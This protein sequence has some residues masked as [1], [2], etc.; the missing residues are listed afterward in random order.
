MA[1]LSSA[2]SPACRGVAIGIAACCAGVV[3][4]GF[5]GAEPVSPADALA[6]F[7]IAEGFRVELFAAEPHVVDPVEMA[8]DESGGVYVAEL[9]DNP[10]DP[11]P[12][13]A[14]LSRIKYLEDRDGDGVIDSHTVFADRLLA[15]EGIAPWKGGLIATAA[16]DILYLKDLDGDRRADLREVLYTGFALAHVEGRLSNPRLGLDNWFYVV[17]HSYPGKIT[18][19]Q[20]PDDPPVNVRNREFRFHPLRGLAEP[21]TGNA[22]FGQSYN[23]WGHWFISHNT[24][25]LRHTVIP[26]GYLRRNPL[27]TV[28]STAQDISDHGRPTAPVFPISKPQQWRIDRTEVRQARFDETQ[29]GRVERL[30]GFFTASS[31]ATVYLGD[32][33]PEGFAGR[34]FVAEGTGNLVH[35]DIVAPSGPTYTA[36]RWPS[37]SDFL[38]S[39]DSWFRP[40]NLSNAPDGNLY[41]LDYYRQYLEHPMFIPEAV[42]RRLNMDFRAGDTLGRIYRIVPD[43]PRSIRPPAVD[44]ESATGEDLVALLEHPNGWHRRT[45]HRLLVERQETA[46]VSRLRAVAREGRL[47]NARLHALWVLEGLD[48]LDADLVA[49]AL[50]DEHPAIRENAIRLA[51]AQLTRFQQQILAATR[52]EDPRVAL[53]AALTAGSFPGSTRV[54]EALADVL[55][56]FPE[57][58]WFRVAV[59]SAPSELAVSV[60]ER[61]IRR[62]D[63]FES[64]TDEKGDLLRDFA[65]TVAARHR[66]AELERLLDWLVNAG[67]MSPSQWK[68]AML[69]GMEEGLAVRRGERVRSEG[70]ARLLELLLGDAS[71]AVR[72]AATG[73][74]RYFDLGPYLRRAIIDAGDDRLPVDQR[75]LAIRVLQ[76]GSYG[77][78]AGALGD[79]LSKEGDPRLRTAAAMSLA[80]FDDPEVARTLVDGWPGYAPATRDVIA[81]LLIRR[82]D[83]AL[84]FADEL[85]AG[86]VNPLDIPAVTRIRFAN[87]PDDE[88]RARVQGRLQLGAGDRDRVVVEHLGVIGLT[89]EPARGKV[90]FDREC[91]SCHLRRN[92]RGRIGPD[93]SGVNNLSKETLLTSILDPSHSIEDRYRNHLLETT[94]GRFYDGI[95]I[96]ETEET[97]TLRGEIEDVTV[98]KTDV[99]EMRESGVSLMPEG[100]EDALSDQELADVIAFLRAGL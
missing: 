15:V 95:L 79:A 21:S 44:I 30:Q 84:A 19:P 25:H 75:I 82:R 93:L 97:V 13:D 4:C 10:D 65:R 87:H 34:V 66:P 7:R 60:L 81:E 55:Y 47:P 99:A 94:D 72:E 86:R 88:V 31:G 80:S 62:S 74:A 22:Q 52:D 11:P 20:R 63:I 32:Q 14:P 76:G 35:C 6:T 85:A 78:V 51:E 3:S 83:L 96:A 27:L 58:P 64:V 56:R 69:R 36:T 98:L 50:S 89:G 45:A 49:G 2:A 46:E 5:R 67:E 38:A 68:T 43:R 42:K 77:D 54:I 90:A 61:L 37:D 1:A 9:L 40:V 16:P 39:A 92:S 41:V 48:S 53:Q 26:P 33:F 59:L 23:E 24:V 17:N 91:A 71:E 12:G 70:A 28:E 57:D 18:S 8:F 29:P 73:I 100:L